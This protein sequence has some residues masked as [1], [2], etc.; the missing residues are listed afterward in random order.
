MS[1][2]AVF[3]DLT[4]SSSSRLDAFSTSKLG[5]SRAG[6]SGPGEC[7]TFTSISNANA[8]KK[9][10]DAVWAEVMS[11]AVPVDDVDSGSSPSLPISAG[12]PSAGECAADTFPE[13]GEGE[14]SCVAR[15]R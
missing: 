3:S 7:L 8:K 2:P 1:N 9:D 6:A 5:F 14:Y 15:V 4:N 13:N 10:E 12:E 11:V